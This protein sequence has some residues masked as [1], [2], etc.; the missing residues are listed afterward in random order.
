MKQGEFF[1]VGVGASAGG[2]E[3]LSQFF[4]HIPENPGTAFIVIQHLHP[5]YTSRLA[6]ILG[7]ITTL[8]V[9]KIQGGE[10][11]L[12][13]HIYTIPEGR[14]AYIRNRILY[15]VERPADEKINTAINF[16]FRSLAIDVRERSIGVI[17]SGT[18][19]DG[20]DGVKAIENH[21]GVVMVQDPGTAI[22][23]GMP[24]NTIHLDHPNFVL[25][26]EKIPA[27]IM[28]YIGQEAK[29]YK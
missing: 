12:P 17:L 11:V 28:T 24:E 29:H 16:F 6:E 26:P 23:A 14:K 7:R 4:S 22:F 21:G 15:L 25:P 10:K 19:T 9:M 5:G 18:G 1:I 8:P 2:I 27:T 13:S 3:A 20:V